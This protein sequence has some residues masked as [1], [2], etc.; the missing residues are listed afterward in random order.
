MTERMSSSWISWTESSMNVVESKTMLTII[1]SGRVFWILGHGRL[2][3]L[4]HGDGVGARA[5]S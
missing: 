4:G 1:P 2:G 3:G 5:V